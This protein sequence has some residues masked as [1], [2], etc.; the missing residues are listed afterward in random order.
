[1]NTIL[2]KSGLL[3]GLLWV[4]VTL[5][6][7]AQSPDFP[8][9]KIEWAVE[10]DPLTFG[11]RGYGVHLRVS[12]PQTERLLLGVGAYAM[13]FPAALVDLNEKNKGE[14]WQVRVQQGVGLFG[15]HHFAGV[16]QGWFVGG[17]LGLQAFDIENDGLKG[18]NS[19]TNV[20][21]MAHGGYTWE[22]FGRGFYLKPWAGVGFTSRLSGENRL[23]SQDYDIAPL[24]GFAA[25]HVG[26]RF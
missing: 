20:L 6:L 18:K 16:H 23:E 12:P 13:D 21:V 4:S 5:S 17:Q 11:F 1:M 24:S 7:Q 26:Y 14:G 19:F 15:E 9:Q 22:P 10:I 3:L 25:L 8:S 2:N